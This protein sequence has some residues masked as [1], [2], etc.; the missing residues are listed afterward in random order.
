[1]ILIA[2]WDREGRG[3]PGK[4]NRGG[5]THEDLVLATG[6][7]LSTVKRHASKLGEITN[8]FP[9][10]PLVMVD[11]DE[12]QKIGNKRFKYTLHRDGFIS[13][14]ETAALLLHIFH[15]THCE[16]AIETAKTKFA[17]TFESDF[18]RL[19]KVGYLTQED[20]EWKTTR[21]VNVDLPYIETI[22]K[23]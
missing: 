10:W 15:D 14:P 17:S 18:K 20:G 6:Q 8:D 16:E 19:V 5:M 4:R 1:M 9:E 22:A 7:S 23:G 11:E 3:R 13:F 12:R 2:L 21:R